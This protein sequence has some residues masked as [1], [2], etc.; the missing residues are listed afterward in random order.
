MWRPKI[1]KRIVTVG[2]LGVAV[3]ALIAYLMRPTVLDVET[4]VVKRGP[5]RETIDD[6]GKTRVRDRFVV[7]AHVTGELHR[8][9]VREGTSIARGQV[10]ASIAPIPLDETTRRQAEARV[11][12]A[13]AVASEAISRVRQARAA[14]DQAKRVLQRR[15]ALVAAG[16]VSS[17]SREQLALESG[18]RDD[19]VAAAEARSRAAEADVNAARAALVGTKASRGALIPIRSP[20]AG[21]VL[22]IPEVSARV[23]SAGAPI[24]EIGDATAIEV[25]ADLLST[26]AVRVCPGQTVEIVEWGGEFPLRGRIR[27]VE[28]SAFTK[29]SALG[30]D[31]QRVN[32]IVD[33]LTIPPALGDGFRVEVRIV[34]WEADAALSVPA[35]ALVQQANATWNVFVLEDG[36]AR[37]RTVRIG[38][39]TSGMV[40][41]T[42]GLP[43]GAEVVLFPSDNIRDGVRLRSRSTT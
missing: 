22:R 28:P 11:A 21:S 15:D 29:V 3:V 40:E 17:E 35:S 19:D 26:D 18:A 32:V 6:E 27:S 24:L 38:H 42:G 33:F 13:L 36:R 5:L 41:V 20:A 2:L 30:I 9:T 34:V 25:V 8:L 4:A 1:S 14:A 43:A 16:A 12:S 23:T 10:V 7:A 31:E 37:A 39:R